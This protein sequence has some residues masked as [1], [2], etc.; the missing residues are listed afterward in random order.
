MCL[1]VIVGRRGGGQDG[2]MGDVVRNLKEV[3][4]SRERQDLTV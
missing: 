3:M 1:I 2:R 4:R